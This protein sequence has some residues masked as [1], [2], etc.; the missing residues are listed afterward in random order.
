[1]C[2]SVSQ[3]DKNSVGNN[4]APTDIAEKERIISE[5]TAK[6]DGRSYVQRQDQW[7]ELWSK[8]LKATCQNKSRSVQQLSF[9]LAPTDIIY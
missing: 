7:K 6:P 2:C 1:M 9:N 8:D 4:I 5:I 3:C